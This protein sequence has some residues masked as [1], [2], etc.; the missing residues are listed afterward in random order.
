MAY[1][2][3]EVNMSTDVIKK[4]IDIVSGQDRIAS[5][6]TI[7]REGYPRG[8]AVVAIKNNG[9]SEFWI[10]TGLKTKKVEDIK[11]NN[12]VSINYFDVVTN[13]TL[14]GTASIIT[15][16]NIK[17][18]MWIAWMHDYYSGPEDRNYCLIKVYVF[19]ARIFVDG[20]N[21]DF[22]RRDKL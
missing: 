7:N 3:L 18:D 13:I 2:Y 9:L 8:S 11:L 20:K 14:I 22:E 15:D 6:V 10:S 4:A 17:K 12:K 1:I 5:F 19:H 21:H 16:N